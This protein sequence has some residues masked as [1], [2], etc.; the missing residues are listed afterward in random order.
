MAKAIS[1]L[2]FGC[3]MLGVPVLF[4]GM[5][6]WLLYLA[7]SIHFSPLLSFHKTGVAPN[8][9]TPVSEKHYAAVAFTKT[10]IDR[11]WTV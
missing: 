2:A 6:R 10:A 9:S 11:G 4:W 7:T 8:R 3:Y 1:R 5:V